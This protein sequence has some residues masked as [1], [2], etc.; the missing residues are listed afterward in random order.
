MTSCFRE[1]VGSG[2][3]RMA[4]ISGMWEA[5]QVPNYWVCLVHAVVLSCLYVLDFVIARFAHF[6]FL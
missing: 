2:E 5:P 1:F 6:V 3:Q 4:R